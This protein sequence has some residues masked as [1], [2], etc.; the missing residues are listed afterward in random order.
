MGNYREQIRAALRILAQMKSMPPA[1]DPI[2]CKAV[3]K[4]EKK[5]IVPKPASMRAP[6]E[7]YSIL[8]DLVRAS[9]PYTNPTGEKKP[10]TVQN[11]ILAEIAVQ[12]ARIADALETK[13]RQ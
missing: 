3:A 6:D 10:S 2:E 1:E 13:R 5:M 11:T 12:L 4:G 9:D 8:M 7:I